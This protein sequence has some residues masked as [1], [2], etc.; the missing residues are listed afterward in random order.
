MSYIDTSV[1]V[2]YYCPERLSGTV[3]KTLAGV[4]EPTISPLVEVEFHSALSIK[5]RTGDLD[6]DSAG[7]IASQFRLHVSDGLYRLV[8][9]GSR[10]YALARDWLGRFTTSLRTLDAL[11]LAVAFAKGLPLLTADRHLA[12]S[13]ES[14]GVGCQWVS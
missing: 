7:R 1:L 2:A 6:R 12:Q 11:H 10:E 4:A 9:V 5:V 14:L 8:P 3:Q 13:A